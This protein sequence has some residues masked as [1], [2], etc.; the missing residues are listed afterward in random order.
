VSL[1]QRYKLRLG[2]GTSLSVDIDGLR[3]WA[4]QDPR[5]VAQAGGSPQWRPIRE[6]LVEEE[7]AARLLR[8]LIPPQTKK[9]AP[10][11][12]ELPQEPAFGQQRGFGEPA[13][14]APVSYLETPALSEPAPFELPPHPEPLAAPSEPAYP[15]PPS[16]AAPAADSAPIHEPAPAPARQ[17]LHV[18]AEGAPSPDG[19]EPGGPPIRLKPLD[20]DVGFRSAWSD[21]G[22][23]VDEDEH[24]PRGAQGEG[25]LVQLLAPLG[26]F[27]SRIL[28]PLGGLLD[29]WSERRA[30]SA[31]SSFPSLSDAPSLPDASQPEVESGPGWRE[32]L[33]EL[34]EKAGAAWSGL[35]A[36]FKRAPA[37]LGETEVDDDYESATGSLSGSL[38]EPLSEPEPD[39]ESEPEPVK[40][41][42]LPPRIAA[43]AAALDPAPR[44]S[45]LPRA[46]AKPPAPLSSIPVVPLAEPVRHEEP[47]D[48]YEGEDEPS[49]FAGPLV[50]WAKRLLLLGVLGA[51]GYYAY[52]ERAVWFPKAGN[53]G[54]TIFRAIDQKAH[55]RERSEQQR[56]A[57]A[58]AAPKLPHLTEPTILKVFAQSPTGVMEASEVFELTRA[59]AERGLDKLQPADAE[60]LRRL[61]QDLAAALRP[62][63]RRRLEEYD[64]ARARRGV[65]PFENPYAMDLVAKGA[66]ALPPE[67]LE[68]L[69]AL[70]EQAVAAGLVDPA[71]AAKDAS[72]P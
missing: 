72:T 23:V 40:R 22:E 15:P 54:Q 65:F 16:Y 33:G 41:A 71:D 35:V 55:S 10:A 29:R 50:F 63:E 70:T 67:K 21:E 44:V 24:E 43:P 52:V 32:K 62:P 6:I 28:A 45:A 42:P 19:S 49:E 8:A 37:E 60:E 47:E 4:A 59:A 26:R 36:R 13:F 57:L 2:D 64:E 68:R 25:P 30:R 38:S 7:N 31:E 3:S 69:R 39:R 1:P 9:D 27:L 53:V 56:Q 5:A 34:G 51:V 14:G 66:R 11:P 58:D 48:V 17:D 12:P 18:L 20:D 46:P 61:E